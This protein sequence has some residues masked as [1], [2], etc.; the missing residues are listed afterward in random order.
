L[1]SK[2]EEGFPVTAIREIKLLTS[3]GHDNIIKVK[4]ILTSEG[5]ITRNDSVFI[6]F[7]YMDHDLAGIMRSLDESHWFSECEIKCLMKQLLTG[8]QFLHR[9]NIIHRDIKSSNLLMNNK[10]ELKIGDFGLARS[11][12]NVEGAK[13]TNKVITSWYR[14]PEIILGQEVYGPEVDMW[15]VGCILGCL[16]IRKPVFYGDTE[17]EVLEKIYQLIGTPTENTYPDIVKLPFFLKFTFNQVYE[18]QLSIKFSKSPN[19]SL[20]LLERL[21]C[22]DP[23]VRITAEESLLSPFFLLD[24]LPCKPNELREFQSNRE[25]KKRKKQNQLKKSTEK[26]Q[27]LNKS[28]EEVNKEES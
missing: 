20:N 15:S 21:F 2:N 27:K 6:V 14:P 3:L 7:E 9:H 18:S 12:S 13:Y 16:I 4:D 22:F 11:L 5:N 19:G 1:T 26:K 10:G 24:P 8:L 25:V 23:K 28:T 17:L